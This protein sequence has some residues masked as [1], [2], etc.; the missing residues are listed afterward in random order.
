MLSLIVLRIMQASMMLVVLLS[1]FNSVSF[2]LFDKFLVVFLGRD[3][4]KFYNNYQVP[5][6]I[7]LTVYFVTMLSYHLIQ[8]F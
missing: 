6:I 1:M 5:Y 3:G 4:C 8:T 7:E 2:L